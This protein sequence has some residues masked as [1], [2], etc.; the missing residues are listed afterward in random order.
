MGHNL[1]LLAKKLLKNLEIQ[2]ISLFKLA[3]NGIQW[4]FW[5]MYQHD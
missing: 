2:V 1:W 4:R 3:M 5:F